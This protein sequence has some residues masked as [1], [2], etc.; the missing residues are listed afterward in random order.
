MVIV[1]KKSFL[2]LPKFGN[3]FAF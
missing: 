1:T 3:N 2:A